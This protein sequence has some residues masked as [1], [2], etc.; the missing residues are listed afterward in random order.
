MVILLIFMRKT[1]YN[2]ILG[3]KHGVLIMLNVVILVS[4]QRE[5]EVKIFEKYT[6]K[7]W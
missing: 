2:C 5:W 1:S 4:C 7:L 3:D 6:W